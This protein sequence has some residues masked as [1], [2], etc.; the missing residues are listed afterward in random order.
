MFEL[1]ISV[2]VLMLTIINVITLNVV[3]SIK[4]AIG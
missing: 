2:N 3:F 4:K 1:L